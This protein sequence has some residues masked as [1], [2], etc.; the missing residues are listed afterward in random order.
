MCVC[1]D[2]MEY[3]EE[4]DYEQEREDERDQWLD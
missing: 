3:C 4:C 2:E 1:D